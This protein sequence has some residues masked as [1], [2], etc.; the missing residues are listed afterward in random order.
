MVQD[1]RSKVAI[2]SQAQE[3]SVRCGQEFAAQGSETPGAADIMAETQ[4]DPEGRGHDLVR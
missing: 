2:C 1:P 4:S 3:Y